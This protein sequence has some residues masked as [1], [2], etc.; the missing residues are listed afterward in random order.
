MPEELRSLQSA[1]QFWLVIMGK[2]HQFIRRV[3]NADQTAENGKSCDHDE[4][5]LGKMEQ[6]YLPA[7]I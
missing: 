3:L 2:I 7:S 5:A 6:I 4:N 1:R